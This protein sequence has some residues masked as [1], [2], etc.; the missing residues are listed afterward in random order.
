MFTEKEFMLI[1]LLETTP[2]IKKDNFLS[3]DDF[4]YSCDLVLQMLDKGVFRSETPKPFVKNHTG[5]GA[6]YEIVGKLYLSTTAKD[7]VQF[8]SFLAYTKSFKK[9]SHWNLNNRLAF[10]GIAVSLLGI[11]VTIFLTV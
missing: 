9:P 7:A 3:D 10:W 8:E 4:D 11:L 6:K 1:K 5:C 2:F